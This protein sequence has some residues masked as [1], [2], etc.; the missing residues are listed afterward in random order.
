MERLSKRMLAMAASCAWAT[1]SLFAGGCKDAQQPE[2]PNPPIQEPVS[3]KIHSIYDLNKET[4]RIDSHEGE[5][6]SSALEMDYNSYTVVPSEILSPTSSIVAPVYARIKK[7]KA[8]NYLLFY[9]GSQIGAHVYFSRSSDLKTWAKGKYLFQM[10][11]NVGSPANPNDSQRYHGADA[12]VLANGDILVAA[13]YRA[14]NGYTNYPECN[15]IVIRRSRDDGISWSAEQVIYRGT[16]WEPYLLQLPSGRIQCYFTDSDPSIREINSIS[17]S[18][19]SLVYSDDNG[20]TWQ[21]SSGVSN[22]YKV[23]RQYIKTL[24]NGIRIYSDQMPVV[25][26]LNDGINMAGI[27]EVMFSD[28]E[29]AKICL[30]YAQYTGTGNG[31]PHLTGDESGPIDRTGNVINGAAGYLVQFPSGETV[32]SCNINNRFSMKVGNSKGRVFNGAEWN[33]GWL[34][35]FA[36]TGYWG[37]MEVIG[38]HELIGTIHRR[39]GDASFVS[40]GIQIGR[41]ILN[42][43]I[44]APASNITVDGDNRDWLHTDALFIGSES[45]AQT[46]FRAASDGAYLYVLAEHLDVDDISDNTMQLYFHNNNGALNADSM[47]ININYAGLAGVVKWSDGNWRS[48]II[49]GLKVVSAVSDND[50]ENGYLAELAIPLSA[51]N[52][53]SGVFRFNAVTVNRTVVDTFTFAVVDDPSTWMLIKKTA[54]E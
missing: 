8:G 34:Q 48:A 52:S 50:G 43:R 40:D 3:M 17:N 2:N 45:P 44:N 28:G 54:A 13:S 29:A 36:G 18:G 39:T 51:L 5:E 41:F 12:V 15:G 4:D 25:R 22:A 9:H 6:A 1:V 19:T 27:M 14:N 24:D 53:P 31:W 33:T 30:V 20:A 23:I 42:H 32:I 11:N 10:K 47:R 35:P 38:S 49:P 16:N 46:V 37:S 21:P 7:T 26:L